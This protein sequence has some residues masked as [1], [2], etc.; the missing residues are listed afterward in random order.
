MQHPTL[1]EDQKCAEVEEEY[2][3]E[4]EEE[5]LEEEIHI[6][7]EE[8]EF[9]CPKFY[10]F[11]QLEE[12]DEN[13]DEWFGTKDSLVLQYPL[14]PHDPLEPLYVQKKKFFPTIGKAPN[15]ATSS[16]AKKRE[17]KEKSVKTTQ[18]KKPIPKLFSSKTRKQQKTTVQNPVVDTLKTV[19]S[20]K[21][22]SST[23]FKKPTSSTL[24]KPTVASIG[25]TSKTTSSQ[26]SKTAKTISK[27]EPKKIMVNSK[28][29]TTKPVFHKPINTKTNY[30][31]VKS[32]LQINK[33]ATVVRKENDSTK[34]NLPKIT[35]TIKNKELEEYKL[36]S[37]D[38]EIDALIG[39]IG[40]TSTA[41]MVNTDEALKYIERIR[42][43]KNQE[44]S[45]IDQIQKKLTDFRI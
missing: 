10:D 12:P 43:E 44:K 17:E 40:T 1:Q 31:H 11:E 6:I 38:L 18:T 37:K 4:E 3:S 28:P 34:P 25:H 2:E 39:T 8:W 14:R 5:E 7:E 36:K 45:S 27:V 33:P 26:I 42:R 30:D 21:S 15:F 22:T 41:T 19:K 35:T 20:T 13:I 9:N 23:I 29:K 24:M 32:K 16:R